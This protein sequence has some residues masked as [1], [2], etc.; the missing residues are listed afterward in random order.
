[1]R[2]DIVVCRSILEVC[3]ELG[4]PFERSNEA[5]QIMDEIYN[6]RINLNA[7]LERHYENYFET[8]PL[9]LL[10]IYQNWIADLFTAA[11]GLLFLPENLRHPSID[12]LTGDNYLDT[13]LNL[14]YHTRDKI[15]FS[16]LLT[17][18]DT[19]LSALGILQMNSERILNRIENNR[20]N[21]YHFPIQRKRIIAGESSSDLSSWLSRIIQGETDITIID[22][23]IYVEIQNFRNYFL[24]HIPHGAK[25][26]IYTAHQRNRA[27][28][29][30]TTD[31][32]LIRE[33]THPFY[34]DWNIEVYIIPPREQHDRDILTNQY[35]ISLGRGISIFGRRGHTFQSNIGVDYIKNI[36]DNTLP[37]ARQIL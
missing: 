32:D 6:K 10:D 15:V 35:A 25:I 24:G 19:E 4:N 34:N 1:M 5:N 8:Q 7:D 3:F 11:E 26:K 18:Y 16:E 12:G 30:T 37:T 27:L 17:D 23:Y 28:R 33:F 29:R 14:T 36:T 2:L 9:H 20:Y 31:R 13:L 21:Q 22:P